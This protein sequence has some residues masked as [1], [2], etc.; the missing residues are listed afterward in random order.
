EGRVPARDLRRPAC[1][2]DDE[3][4]AARGR[5]EER[6]AVEPGDGN[7]RFAAPGSLSGTAVIGQGCDLD[8]V[9]RGAVRQG[10]ALVKDDRSR[11]RPQ[12]GDGRKRG[13][14]VLE[15]ARCVDEVDAAKPFA[16]RRNR[17]EEAQM[18]RLER[19]G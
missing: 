8:R 15:G 2:A 14:G 12:D 1:E 5:A 19:G 17:V 11:Q 7:E 13:G 6:I 10:G 16:R 4:I 9:E 18:V 3:I